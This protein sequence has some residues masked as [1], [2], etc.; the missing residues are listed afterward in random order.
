MSGSSKHGDRKGN[1]VQK[2]ISFEDFTRILLYSVT[3]V[4]YTF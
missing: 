1:I 2:V 3:V 4:L